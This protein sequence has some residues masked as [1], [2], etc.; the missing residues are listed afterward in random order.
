MSTCAG[1]AEKA[2]TTYALHAYELDPGIDGAIASVEGAPPT[3]VTY[4]PASGGYFLSV[5]WAGF[6]D[7]GDADTFSFTPPIDAEVN[8]SGTRTTVSFHLLR[9]AVD[10]STAP[11]R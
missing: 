9:A 3:P 1:S 6:E 2:G 11:A 10:G 4:A 5:L 7:A 8:P